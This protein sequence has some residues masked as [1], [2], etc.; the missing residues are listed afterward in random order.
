MTY[1][2]AFLFPIV[3]LNWTPIRWVSNLILFL[4]HYLNKNVFA[5]Q[6]KNKIMQKWLWLNSKY[7]WRF[8]EFRLKNSK[9][10]QKI[11]DLLTNLGFFRR[12]FWPPIRE[13]Y[14]VK[15]KWGQIHSVVTQ[16]S[17]WQSWPKAKINIFV[18]TFWRPILN[19]LD[20][21]WW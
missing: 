1:S 20:L 19:I 9:R 3:K 6:L 16:V 15:W 17:P 8:V 18:P 13:T 2:I 10:N 7:F 11:F 14:G 12:L 4:Y 21:Q 5:V